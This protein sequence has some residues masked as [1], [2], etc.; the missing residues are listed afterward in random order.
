MPI[1]LKNRASTPVDLMPTQ[2]P[3]QQQVTAAR[4]YRARLVSAGK[5]AS[6]EYGRALF[7][8]HGQQVAD[9]LDR[10]L[11][12]F[13][14]DPAIAGPHYEALP[15]LLHF[16]N[17]GPKPIA[18]VA[19]LTVLDGISGRH[20]HRKLAGAIGRAIENEVRAGRIHEYDKDT[21]RVLLRH[22]G[23]ARV[24][25]DGTLRSLGLSRE[26]WS[27]HDRFAVGALLLNLIAA[28]TGLI[29]CVSQTIRGRPVPM[30]EAT[31]ITRELIATTP[32]DVRPDRSRPS[33]NPPDP[34]TSYRGLVC[35]QD[36]LPTDY[37]DAGGPMVLQVINRLSSQPLMVDPWMCEVQGS[38]WRSNIRGLFKCTRDPLTPPQKP[39]PGAS[40]EQMREWRRRTAEAWADERQHARARARIDWDI[41]EAEAFSGVPVWFRWVADYRGRLYPSNKSTSHQGPDHQKALV[42]LPG[43][44]A[45]HDA[46]EW[47]LK[48]AAGHWGLGRASWD[49]RLQWGRA[50][51]D[52]LRAI[53]EAPLDRLELWRDAA[54][55]WQFLQQARAFSLWL[56]DP[57]TP[58]GAPIRLDQ[59]T[60]GLGIAAALVRDARLARETNLIGSTR[61]DIYGNVAAAVTATLQLH[62]EAGL[63]HQQR[64]A[65]RWLEL[66][67]DRSLTK[68]P[69]MQAVYGGT[70]QSLF[71]G[72]ADHLREI[73]PPSNAA[74]YD[75]SVVVPARYLA[76]VM[77]G[78][79]KPEL[80]PLLQLKDWLKALSAAVVKGGQPLRWT[81][82]SGFPVVI[83]AKQS[84]R[85]AVNTLVHG[86]PRWEAPDADLRRKELS[87]LASNRSIT[88]NLIH[89]FDAA[90][91]AA[92]IC[93]AEGV[94]AYALPTHDCFA[95][96]PAR[97]GWLHQT[98]HSELRTLYLPDWLAELRSEIACY[99]KAKK[100]PAPPMVGTLTPGSIGQN[101]Y[102]FS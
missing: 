95:V 60:S 96:V 32:L 46:A 44:P 90:L 72:L 53:A 25:A 66:G 52:R 94:G 5:E 63:P 67:I 71:D 20:R 30:V 81:T 50:N 43:E 23:R 17:T 73:S 16:K 64:N 99:S 39:A 76:G 92:V 83:G 26:R 61:H 19:V 55:P 47:I 59:T 68:R 35:R 98:L 28:E 33:L 1:E 86:R 85:A 42:C 49:E 34:C 7:A 11:T 101:P 57:S 21:L 24:V 10:L 29:H 77:R 36:G 91:V 58:I 100:L 93:R 80:E 69:V 51:I 6:T 31:P 82:P 3:T 48:A 12:R 97:V 56:Q 88:A 2:R 13:V 40:A 102:C 54:D 9:G 14:V 62:L 79:L 65:A 78:I 8:E 37:V 18:A 22:E 89:S 74:E 38:A 15:L 45:D 75:R 84:P 87:V 4:A 41:A 27:Q 70:F